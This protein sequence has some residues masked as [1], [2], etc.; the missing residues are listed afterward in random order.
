MDLGSSTSSNVNY[1]GDS[2]QFTFSLPLLQMRGLNFLMNS[3]LF[4]TSKVS[5]NEIA[6]IIAVGQRGTN[7]SGNIQVFNLYI[8]KIR[9]EI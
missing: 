5:E 8:L 4:C 3:K 9:H 6:E 2:E 1:M 7:I